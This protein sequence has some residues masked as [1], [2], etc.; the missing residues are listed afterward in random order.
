LPYL[1]SLGNLRSSW[2]ASGWGDRVV[3]RLFWEVRQQTSQNVR[4]KW[5]LFLA[6]RQLP[7]N[8][9]NVQPGS[10][11]TPRPWRPAQ[12]GQ[13]IIQVRPDCGR[14]RLTECNLAYGPGRVALV[15]LV[16]FD[17]S[18][19]LW[20]CW[21]PLQQISSHQMQSLATNTT[22]ELKLDP[23]LFLSNKIH[24]MLCDTAQLSIIE[25][26]ICQCI[27]LWDGR[28]IRGYLW[29]RKRQLPKILLYRQDTCILY[30][31][32]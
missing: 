23:T 29:S 16:L 4:W 24:K 11:F 7:I 30:L 13:E 12:S 28:I 25:C 1:G 27:F 32:K 10:L 6:C 22:V 31:A 18:T 15:D 8:Q 9:Q 3:F 19:G 2:Y 5:F 20:H 26:S 21:L 14:P 17:V